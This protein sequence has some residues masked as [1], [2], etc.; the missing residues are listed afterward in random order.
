MLLYSGIVLYA[1]A[2]AFETTTGLPKLTSIL[3]VGLA[4]AFYSSVGGIKAVLITDIFQAILMF[5]SLIIIII[6]ASF[7]AG[8]IDKIWDIADKGGRI[9][10]DK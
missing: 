7:S 5:A 2:L 1:P 4:C 3:S 8:G 6:S 10:F 9:E